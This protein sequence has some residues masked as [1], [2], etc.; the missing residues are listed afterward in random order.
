MPSYCTPCDRT[1]GTAWALKAH[2]VDSRLPHPSCSDCGRAF[3]SQKS[4]D[5]HV[6]SGVHQKRVRI[7]SVVRKKSP[8]SPPVIQQ[9]PKIVQSASLILGLGSVGSWLERESRWSMIPN[10]QQAA[11]LGALALHCHMPDELLK[12]R[13][14]LDSNAQCT[15]K[16]KACDGEF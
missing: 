13:Y 16:C 11:A 4:L 12:N 3:C 1:F 15:R 2:L 8:S 6:G 7:K 10:S 9:Q 5:S 14:I